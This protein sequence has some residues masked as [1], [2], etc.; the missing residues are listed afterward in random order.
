[1]KSSTLRTL[2]FLEPCSL[3][4]CVMA[5]LGIRLKLWDAA[6]P[7]L[8]LFFSYLKCWVP[9]GN[10]AYFGECPRFWQV[11]GL[12]MPMLW[13]WLCAEKHSLA[14]MDCNSSTTLMCYFS[15]DPSGGCYEFCPD[16]QSRGKLLL[17]VMFA[18]Q[19]MV[20]LAAQEAGICPKELFRWIHE[21]TGL[22]V[23]RALFRSTLRFFLWA[24]FSRCAPRALLLMGW[25]VTLR[26][27]PG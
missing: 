24:K 12:M 10:A 14:L 15:G 23:F 7:W 19:R 27:N 18:S 25:L 11:Y 1:M 9:S 20:T 16:W 13:L 21:A 22:H 8:H 4:Y 3:V 5:C 17:R 6:G 2:N 26:L